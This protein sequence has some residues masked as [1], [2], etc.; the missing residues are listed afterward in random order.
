MVCLSFCYNISRAFKYRASY[1]GRRK[2]AD[3]KQKTVLR[4]RVRLS[5]GWRQGLIQIVVWRIIN[6]HIQKHLTR[7]W[8]WTRI[9]VSP[10]DFINFEIFYL[11][12]VE[13]IMRYQILEL[14]TPSNIISNG[15]RDCSHDHYLH[16]RRVYSISKNVFKTRP[17]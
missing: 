12:K 14:I 5:G 6:T 2:R 4:S 10:N 15:K 11:P 16:I 17:R 9:Q 13:D 3:I 8:T 1:C 7:C